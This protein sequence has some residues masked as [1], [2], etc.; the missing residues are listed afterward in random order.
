MICACFNNDNNNKPIYSI[1][2]KCCIDNNELKRA[3]VIFEYMR[4]EVCQPDEMTYSL[5]IH[6]C[7]K[8]VNRYVI[9]MI[10][11][12]SLLIGSLFY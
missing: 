4:L 12:I 8:V 3:W 7:A 11:I 1:L 9:M 5:M 2:I 6:A 10:I